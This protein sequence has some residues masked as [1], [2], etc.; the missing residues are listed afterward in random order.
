[1]A[2]SK[3]AVTAWQKQRGRVLTGEPT[4]QSNACEK[5]FWILLDE[6]GSRSDGV[7]KS[8]IDLQN[9]PRHSG[10]NTHSCL[11]QDWQRLKELAER[12]GRRTDEHEAQVMDKF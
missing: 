12:G 6:T 2:E 10:S 7:P 5:A 1:M 3:L 11:I 9:N 4:S 8:L